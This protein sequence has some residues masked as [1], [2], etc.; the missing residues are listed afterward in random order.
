MS[1]YIA[2]TGG[3][4]GTQAFKSIDALAK[5][6]ENNVANHKLSYSKDGTEIYVGSSGSTAR[7]F[8]YYVGGYLGNYNLD[9]TNLPVM[10]E[11]ICTAIIAEMDG[12][13]DAADLQDQAARIVNAANGLRLMHGK[14][15]PSKATE[16]NF[17]QAI[18]ALGD[19]GALLRDKATR[20]TQWQQQLQA[21]KQIPGQLGPLATMLAM[22]F[23]LN[24]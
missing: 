5:V 7:T 3:I 8:G 18:R 2:S 23:Q 15:Y 16:G 24:Q 10:A 22:K 17:H 4:T 20:I 9:H 11:R 6:D 1:T 12:N 21:A 19:T 14:H 13:N